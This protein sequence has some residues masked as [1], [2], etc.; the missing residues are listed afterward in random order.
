MSRREP[1]DR[2]P[3]R[4]ATWLAA[5]VALI[6]AATMV[7]RRSH[8]APLRALVGARYDEESGRGRRGT[9]ASP[10]ARDAGHETLDMR[11]GLM[12]KLVLLLG[13]VALCMIFAMI[14]LRLWV[15]SVQR[16]NQPPLTSQQ[17]AI[18][19]PPGPNLQNDPLGD[20]ARLRR[21]EDT[22]LAGTAYL[23]ENRTHARIPLDR[24][25][26]LTVGQPLAPPP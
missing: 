13:S 14:G 20:I 18:I 9:P 5:G 24:A 19:T 25:M 21:A 11:G 7:A 3:A 8:I 4:T 1:G 17:T 23:D 22:Q 26:A 15:T 2:S 12:A 6:G 16:S 10:V